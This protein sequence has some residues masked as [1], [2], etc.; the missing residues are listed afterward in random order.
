MAG[1]GRC[2]AATTALE[3]NAA[4]GEHREESN[5]CGHAIVWAGFATVGCGGVVG[6][7]IFFLCVV[8]A[9][10][11]RDTHYVP[12][13]LPYVLHHSHC[14]TRAP[15]G[16]NVFFIDAVLPPKSSRPARL[17]GIEAQLIQPADVNNSLFSFWAT[18]VCVGRGVE[19]LKFL[20]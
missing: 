17:K 11:A 12:L 18:E 6:T 16:T 5:E 2:R 9:C 13:L 7:C 10:V 15:N 1:Y 14:T 8:Y 19:I 20:L 3:S 4:A